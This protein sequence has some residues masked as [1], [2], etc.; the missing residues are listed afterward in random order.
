M[1]ASSPVA[2]TPWIRRDTLL[3]LLAAWLVAFT[4]RAPL[5]AAGPLL[6]AACT[7]SLRRARVLFSQALPLGPCR[8]ATCGSWL[9]DEQLAEYL[10]ATSNIVA[11]QRRFRLLPGA[12][13]GD[14]AVFKHVFLREQPP[15]LEELPQRTTL[16]RAIVQHLRAGRHWRTRVGWLE[17]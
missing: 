2:S 10:P 8:I 11:F 7:D 14:A 15:S 6:P 3:P 5:V 13:D 1:D 4:C 9:L 16:E 17:L 12:G